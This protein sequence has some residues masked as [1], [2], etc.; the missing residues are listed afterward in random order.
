[1]TPA[2]RPELV[3]F[4]EAFDPHVDH[5]S[6]ALTARGVDWWRVPLHRFP[7][8][9]MM[10]HRI[11]AGAA[12]LV[13]EDDTARV[14]LG[15]VRA[16]WYRRT[17]RPMLPE[18]LPR[19]QRALARGECHDFLDGVWS[20]LADRRWISYPWATRRAA[21]KSD[22]LARAAALGF[23][24]PRTLSSNDPAEV[25]RFYRE[26]G[27]ARSVIFKTHQPIMVPAADPET[28][29]VVY[30]SLLDETHLDRLEEI[31]CCPG[32]FQQYVAKDHEIRVTVIGDRL[33]ACRIFSQ[34]RE[35]ACVDWRN[36][37]WRQPE[38][39]LPRHEPCELP[40]AVAQVI[41]EMV[42]GYHLRFAT[43]DLIVTPDGSWVFLELN[44][45]GQ[46]AWIETL[47]RLPLTQALVDEL[48]TRKEDS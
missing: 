14:D 48:L 38:G 4:T 11:D 40:E 27:G 3:V 20:S 19:E 16:V 23:P 45:N 33:F 46:W 41:L 10:S 29:G 12:H 18:D 35:D 31:A 7:L 24:I 37:D 22:Q 17:P 34:E 26:C 2:R 42:R 30:S 25:R 8:E 43:A 9:M 15:G 13:I 36:W 32:I 44:P 5:V 47:T 1:M 21:C 6:T 39:S 28:C